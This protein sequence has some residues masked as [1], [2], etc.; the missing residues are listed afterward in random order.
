[1]W[2]GKYLGVFHEQRRDFFALARGEELDYPSSVRQ[3]L[4]RRSA[5][6]PAIM[7][8]PIGGTTEGGRVSK[9]FGMSRLGEME[10]QRMVMMM[11]RRAETGLTLAMV[12]L[13]DRRLICRR[14]K[15]SAEF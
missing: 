13:S 5:P 7:K 2:P 14:K 11:M 9:I 6:Q 4:M 3:M 15:R 1:M 12:E 10:I 8:T